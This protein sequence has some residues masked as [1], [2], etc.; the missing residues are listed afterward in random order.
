M[1]YVIQPPPELPC[2]PFTSEQG[3]DYGLVLQCAVAV[4][5][6]FLGKTSA[7]ISL[8][9]YSSLTDS[10]NRTIIQSID[11]V[12]SE[13]RQEDYVIYRAAPS[14]KG[15]LRGRHEYWCQVLVNGQDSCDTVSLQR[16][17]ATVI[18]TPSCYQHLPQC[19]QDLPLGLTVSQDALS[20]SSSTS[21]SCTDSA[22][23][24][25]LSGG[26]PRN[27]SLM[28][29][30]RNTTTQGGAAAAATVSR[31]AVIVPTLFLSILL[32]LA[33]FAFIVLLVV[34]WR[35][36]QAQKYRMKGIYV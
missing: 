10:D 3:N 28:T 5:R 6:T 36:R 31:A 9:L 27:A 4:S 35:N 8:S 23:L 24:E 29:T 15:V 18:R 30:S 34:H 22:F 25:S 26:D 12:L 19:T 11:L 14:L 7:Q 2:N 17:S 21:E 16:S 1:I 13:V 20:S 32:V 33:I